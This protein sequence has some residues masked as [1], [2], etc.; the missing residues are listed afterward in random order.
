[1]LNSSADIDTYSS[2]QFHHFQ[3]SSNVVY[4]ATGTV[5]KAN[6]PDT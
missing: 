1:V 5:T 6:T 3:S 4:R 2:N